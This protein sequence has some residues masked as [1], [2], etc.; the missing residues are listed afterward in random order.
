MRQAFALNEPK[1]TLLSVCTCIASHADHDVRVTPSAATYIV[2]DTVRPTIPE[3]TETSSEWVEFV[4]LM[5]ANWLQGESDPTNQLSFLVSHFLQFLNDGVQSSFSL[6]SMN[7]CLLR[8]AHNLGRV[9]VTQRGTWRSSRSACGRRRPLPH[10]NI[11]RR[12]SDLACYSILLGVRVVSTCF[13]HRR[14]CPYST[15]MMT[16]KG[17]DTLFHLPSLEGVTISKSRLVGAT[18]LHCW[19]Y[20]SFPL[21]DIPNQPLQSTRRTGPAVQEVYTLQ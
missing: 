3:P 6:H 5:A 17:Q 21:S 12:P 1:S 19:Y 8:P 14:K 7:L 10:N 4:S 9:V 13:S 20:G 18:C 15:S 11:N 2:C 16:T